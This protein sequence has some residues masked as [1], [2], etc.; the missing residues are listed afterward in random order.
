MRTSSAGPLARLARS[1]VALLLGL[2]LLSPSSALASGEDVWKDCGDED[3]TINRK[4]SQADYTDALANPVADGAEYSPCLDLIRQAQIR[5]AS[6]S[7][8]G[9]GTGGGSGGGTGT[10]GSG[11]TG[12]TVT[13]D[14]LSSALR[15]SGVNPAAA[16]AD[17]AAAPAPAPVTVGGKRIDLSSE[18]LPSIASTLSLPLPLAASAI[19]VLLSAGLPLVRFVVARFGGPPTGTT[20]AP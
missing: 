19:V 12:T 9:G 15:S 6:N 7:G 17:A 18:R 1:L 13:P 16:G 4:H 10:G 5:D 20:A 3:G 8:G 2:V 11:G 14:D